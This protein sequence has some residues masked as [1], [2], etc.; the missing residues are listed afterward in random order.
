MVGVAHFLKVSQ[1]GAL[2]LLTQTRYRNRF[3]KDVGE[4]REEGGGRRE[5]A[6]AEGRSMERG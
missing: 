4:R 2:N 6:E 3:K 1:S 5:E